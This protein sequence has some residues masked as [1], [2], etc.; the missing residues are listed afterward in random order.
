MTC[1]PVIRATPD[2]VIL[3]V[4]VI[5]RSSRSGVDGERG[6]ALRVRLH[7]PP[8]EGAANDELVAVLADALGVPRRAVAIVKGERSRSKQAKVTG[9][10][11][12]TAR[13]RLVAAASG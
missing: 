10:D 13:L 7:A 6:N 2:G 12:T 9:L 4:R 1:G 5:P 8:V 3:A 11:E